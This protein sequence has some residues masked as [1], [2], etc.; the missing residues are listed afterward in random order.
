MDTMA[1]LCGILRCTPADLIEVV[2]GTYAGRQADRLL[3]KRG[4]CGGTARPPGTRAPLR[5][6]VTV[7]RLR[8]RYVGGATRPVGAQPVIPDR[9]RA[10]TVRA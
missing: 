7:P 8:P 10:Q 3:R 2:E 1:A 5:G 6:P 9:C 4:R